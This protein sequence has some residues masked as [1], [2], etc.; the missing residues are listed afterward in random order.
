MVGADV[1]RLVRVDAL[2]GERVVHRLSRGGEGVGLERGRV[3]FEIF[4]AAFGD[5]GIFATVV[6]IIM[7]VFLENNKFLRDCWHL[8][9][10]VFLCVVFLC[11]SE[12]I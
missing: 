9:F 12:G 5:R 2:E 11:P 7:S 4:F 10:V 6:I 8:E 1:V 3:W